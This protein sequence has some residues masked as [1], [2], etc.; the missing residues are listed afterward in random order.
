MVLYR[1]SGGRGG[2]PKANSHQPSAI[3]YWLSAS[4]YLNINPLPVHPV[5]DCPHE[6][7]HGEG[8][9][10]GA[11]FWIAGNELIDFIIH[12]IPWI[13]IQGGALFGNSIGNPDQAKS[14]GQESD[15]Y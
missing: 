14:F 1:R 4:S 13:G 3:S 10:E 15:L 11:N 7:D 9:K 8:K 5:T 12:E 6:K 2:K